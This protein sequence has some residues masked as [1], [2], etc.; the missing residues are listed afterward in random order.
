MLSADLRALYPRMKW[1]SQSVKVRP[2]EGIYH[3]SNETADWGELGRVNLRRTKG[4][5]TFEQIQLA[6]EQMVSTLAILDSVGAELTAA[7]MSSAM[8]CL[9]DEIRT[10]TSL[11]GKNKEVMDLD[12]VIEKIFA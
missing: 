10:L 3:A 5:S 1:A 7:K 4:M 11:D 6:A 9:R 2:A 12:E 8:D